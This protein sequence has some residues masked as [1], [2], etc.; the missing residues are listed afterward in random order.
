V[1]ERLALIRERV[2][3]A[4][5]RAGRSPTEVTIVAVSKSFPAQAIEEAAAA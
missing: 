2:A 1:A 3:H 4:A 5:E